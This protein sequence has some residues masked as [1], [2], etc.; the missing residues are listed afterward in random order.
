MTVCYLEVDDE[1]T[2]AVA[3]L[4]SAEDRDFILFL[5]A[6]S[7]VATSRI[8]LRLLAREGQERDVTVAVVSPEAGV[9]SLAISAG[10]PAYASVEEAETALDDAGLTGSRVS[11]ADAGA[12]ASPAAAAALPPQAAAAPPP[13]RDGAPSPAQAPG[14]R[15]ATLPRGAPTGRGGATL[16]KTRILP[17]S[18]ASAVP[19]T[20]GR[21]AGAT[22]QGMPVAGPVPAEAPPWA[23]EAPVRG[24][25]RPRRRSAW[26]LLLRLAILGA[27]VG[28]AAYAAYLFLPN[29]SITLRP[30]TETAGPLTIQVIADPETAV[31]DTAAGLVPAERIDIPLSATESFASTGTEVVQTRATGEVR[32]TSENTLFEVPIPEGTRV[33]TRAG[34]EFETTE[35]VTI[36]QASFATGPASLQAAIRAVRPGPDGNVPAGEV[37]E[38]PGPIAEQLVVATNPESTTG[39]RRSETPVVS[40][41]DY[42]AAVEELSQRLDEQLASA[43]ADPDNTPRGLRMFPETATRDEVTLDVAAGDLVGQAID[44]FSLTAGARATVLAV[45]ETLV[46]EAAADRLA[47]DLPPEV[48][49]FPESVTTSVGEAQVRSGTIVYEVTAQGEQYV[50]LDTAALVEAIRGKKVSEARVILE[51]HGSVEITPWPD[52]IDTVPDDA[53]RIDLTLLEPQRSSQ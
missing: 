28:G 45:D 35:S 52:F 53:R 43:L 33:A 36:P 8:N 14:V 4:R 19:M 44:T 47:A 48:R 2:D 11:T 5:P 7:R 10:M 25:P 1:I 12:A 18:T 40:R 34:V 22:G 31:P 41:A 51:T 20:A 23:H 16:E 30:R 21:L 39:G 32:L 50:P 37:T 9:R 15:A 38:L 42:D 46:A 17:R 13:A 24:R 3:R 27:L 26:G 49:L 29:A 6:G